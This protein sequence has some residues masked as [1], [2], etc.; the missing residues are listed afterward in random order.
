MRTPIAL[1][2]LG[3]LF[4]CD[5]GDDSMGMADDDDAA[6]PMDEPRGCA[7]EAR[8]DTYVL[9]MAKQGERVQVAFVDA[10]PAPPERGDNTWR[11]AITQAGAPLSDVEV[12]VEPYMPDHMHG[13]SIEAHV[14]AAD[15]P[16][17]YVIE[18]V[19]MFMPGLWQ[20]QLYMT[21]PDGSDDQVQFDFCVDP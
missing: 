1:A 19:N 4:A 20:V 16:G 6:M 15:A 17:E 10:L 2:L 14:T 9:G 3:S 5:G 13:T 7:T 21:L 11:V 18:P 12:E 8:A